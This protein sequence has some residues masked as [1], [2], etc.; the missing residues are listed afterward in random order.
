MCGYKGADAQDTLTHLMEFCNVTKDQPIKMNDFCYKF[1]REKD[2]LTNLESDTVLTLMLECFRDYKS[3]RPVD[4]ERVTKLTKM[5][6][7]IHHNVN[8][9]K[10]CVHS[11]VTYGSCVCKQLGI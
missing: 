7:H 5:L 6:S 2:L 9:K 8:R 3:K 10:V 4:P 11:H 1:I